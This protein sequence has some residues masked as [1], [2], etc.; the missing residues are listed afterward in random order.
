MGKADI[1]IGAILSALFMG[2]AVWFLYFATTPHIDILGLVWAMVA[3]M[4]LSVTLYDYGR[5]RKAKRASQ[6]TDSWI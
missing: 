3:G 5:Y 1:I 2:V 4:R 6:R